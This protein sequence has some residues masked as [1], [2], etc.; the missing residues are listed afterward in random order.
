MT[1]TIMN[2]EEKD[3]KLGVSILEAEVSR[4]TKDNGELSD[5]IGSLLNRL[6]FYEKTI[7]TVYSMADANKMQRLL[8]L[9]T[10]I[11]DEQF[12]KLLYR[13]SRRVR[14]HQFL[15]PPQLF[16]TKPLNLLQILHS[17]PTYLLVL[18]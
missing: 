1:K 17:L 2:N 10:T 15:Y 5:E 6:E 12:L 13:E 16:Y 18:I 14:I 3:Y 4:L 8:K 7:P 9:V 11:T